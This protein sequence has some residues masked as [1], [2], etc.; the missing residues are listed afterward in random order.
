MAAF[1]RQF[2][3]LRDVKDLREGVQAQHH[4]WNPVLDMIVLPGVAIRVSPLKCLRGQDK[5]CVRQ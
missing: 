1:V 5:K 2:V 4:E 3:G